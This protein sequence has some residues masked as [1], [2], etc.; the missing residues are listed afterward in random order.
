M[1]L[2]DIPVVSPQVKRRFS[3]IGTGERQGTI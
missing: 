2:V 3:G 1:N